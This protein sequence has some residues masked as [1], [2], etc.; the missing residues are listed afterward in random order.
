MCVL[1]LGA[2]IPDQ[3]NAFSQTPQGEI[4]D[5]SEQPPGIEPMNPGLRG[6]LD[7]FPALPWTLSPDH[8]CLVQSVDGFRH[9]VVIGVAGGTD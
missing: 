8:L 1:P 5:R 3:H 2:G 6:E 9:G 7:L 4:S